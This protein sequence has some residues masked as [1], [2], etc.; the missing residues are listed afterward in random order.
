[1]IVGAPFFL[2]QLPLLPQHLVSI[3]MLTPIYGF[4][5]LTWKIIGI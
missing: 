4:D 2:P 3:N 1:M 5:V